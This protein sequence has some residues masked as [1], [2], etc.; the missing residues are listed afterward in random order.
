MLHA[1]HC[2]LK[3]VLKFNPPVPAVE[4]SASFLELL[5]QTR[6]LPLSTIEL[7]SLLLDC[8]ELFPG[9]RQLLFELLVG[10]DIGAVTPEEIAVSVVA[11]MI[12][13]RRQ[14]ES[15]WRELSKSIFTNPSLRG[16]LK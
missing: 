13:V 14:P 12:A 15:K 9:L 8:F 3:L 2:W 6:H 11:E 7:L 10:L 16:L 4:Q 5:L 1:L